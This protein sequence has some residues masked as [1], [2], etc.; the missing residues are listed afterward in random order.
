MKN[1][2]QKLLEA[3][4]NQ[5]LTAQIVLEE[6]F[7]VMKKD[8]TYIKNERLHDL[9][10]TRLSQPE[11]VQTIKKMRLIIETIEKYKLS[12]PLNK[13]INENQMHDICEKYSLIFGEVSRYTG[14]IPEKNVIEMENFKFPEHLNRGLFICAPKNDMFLNSW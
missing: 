2:T 6:T 1:E 4:H 14:T 13:L 11:E 7:V 9:G 5:F 12:H 8:P 10:F 3:I